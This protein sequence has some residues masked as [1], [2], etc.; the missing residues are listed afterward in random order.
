MCVVGG[1]LWPVEH[2]FGAH[3]IVGAKFV[4]YPKSPNSHWEMADDE[5]VVITAATAACAP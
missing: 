1:L 4:T 3:G 2:W 5:A